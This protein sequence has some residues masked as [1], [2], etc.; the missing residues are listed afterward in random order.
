MTTPTHPGPED[1]TVELRLHPIEGGG[2]PVA[3]R[4]RLIRRS[5]T[6]RAAWAT[7]YVLLGLVGAAV[8]VVVPVLHLCST[9]AL[10][11]LGG[12]MAFRAWKSDLLVQDIEGTCPGCGEPV[13]LLG[14]VGPGPHAERCKACRKLLEAKLPEVSA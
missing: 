2:P 9:W 14:G 6:Y 12:V 1:V 7:F 4:A 11:L 3:T 8:F 13:R 10:P 5:T